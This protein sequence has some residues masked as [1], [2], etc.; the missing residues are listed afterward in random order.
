MK[1]K[2]TQAKEKWASI[3]A[4]GCFDQPLKDTSHL[5]VLQRILHIGARLRSNKM[6]GQRIEIILQSYYF[7]FCKEKVPLRAQEYLR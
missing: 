2:S 5:L 1:K 7:F 6:G 3:Q 4:L